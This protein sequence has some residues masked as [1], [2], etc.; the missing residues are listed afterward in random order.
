MFCAL[1]VGRDVFLQKETEQ[2][3]MQ[4]VKTFQ[5]YK[6]FIEYYN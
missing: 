5:I 3:L 6:C 1:G 4:K 2:W